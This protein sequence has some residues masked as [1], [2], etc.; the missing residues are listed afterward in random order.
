MF[1][2]SQTRF[3]ILIID[4]E[5]ALPISSQLAPLQ[6]LSSLMCETNHNVYMIVDAARSNALQFMRELRLNTQPILEGA[7]QADL[8][9]VSPYLV[10]IP[11]RMSLA[12]AAVCLTWG[13]STGLI[14]TASVDFSTVKKHLRTL[15][16]ADSEDGHCYFRF[17]D[18]RV[19]LA[20]LSTSTV[21]ERARICGPV[22]RLI[23]ESESPSV[24][25]IFEEEHVGSD[26]STLVYLRPI[27]LAAFERVA[28]ASFEERLHFYVRRSMPINCAEFSDR[29]LV[30]KV[31]E[32][33][34]IARQH[35][36]N[37]QSGIAAF[38]CL[39]FLSLV[40]PFYEI[41]EVATYLTHG[42]GSADQRILALSKRLNRNS[43]DGL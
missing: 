27:H 30:D 35:G 8:H 23:V 34:V 40:R 15:T 2:V 36:A 28:E 17:Y 21:E 20:F 32:S 10:E 11:R 38:V 12:L 13:Q 22:S 19:L 39:T 26:S 25:A 33:I 7:A 42:D 9:E 3:E 37:N 41:P 16:M 43:K 31:R 24:P 1:A 14:L 29:N 18:P 4:T 6:R 5:E